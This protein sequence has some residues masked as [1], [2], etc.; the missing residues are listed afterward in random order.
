MFSHQKIYSVACV[1]CVHDVCW[2]TG[3]CVMCS[4]LPG[5]AYDG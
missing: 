4:A 5:V 3:M 1:K 2:A